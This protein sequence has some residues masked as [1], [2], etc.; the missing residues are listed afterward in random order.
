MDKDLITIVNTINVEL[1]PVTIKIA[2]NCYVRPVT[3]VM[4]ATV[5][6]VFLDT[7]YKLQITV[8]NNVQV[9]AKSVLT[10]TNVMYAKKELIK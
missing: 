8:V 9:A 1:V 10:T 3:E 4:P 6:S 5:L 2:V 7:I